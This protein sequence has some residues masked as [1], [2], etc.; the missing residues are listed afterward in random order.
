MLTAGRKGNAPKRRI[1]S[2]AH[3]V[4]PGVLSL[5]T[6]GEGSEKAT[7]LQ[8]LIKS[9]S[10]SRL[11]NKYFLSWHCKIS[12]PDSGNG[13]LLPMT[14]QLG[15]RWGCLVSAD[16]S[17]FASRLLNFPALH[18][19]TQ[20]QMVPRILHQCHKLQKE[21]CRREPCGEF[22][23]QIVLRSGQVCG[24]YKRRW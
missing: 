6:W 12:E 4:T 14:P 10:T 22:R 9:F 20:C 15:W 24:T 17:C 11:K 19:I 8:S 3:R 18:L 2:V 5:G 7:I 21:G 16:A 1:S 13:R 23:Q